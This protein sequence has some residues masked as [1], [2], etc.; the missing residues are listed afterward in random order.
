MLQS[1]GNPQAT[2]STF[3]CSGTSK[4]NPQLAPDTD[5]ASLTPAFLQLIF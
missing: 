4:D 3:K 2:D 1:Q 5:R